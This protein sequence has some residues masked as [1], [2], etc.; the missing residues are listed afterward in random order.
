M[1]EQGSFGWMRDIIGIAELQK[2]FKT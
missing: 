2:M 1:Q